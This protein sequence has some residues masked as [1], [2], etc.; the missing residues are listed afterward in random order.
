MVPVKSQKT[1]LAGAGTAVLH[2]SRRGVRP[3]YRDLYG[4]SLFA[5]GTRGKQKAVIRICHVVLAT[6]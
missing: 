3:H 5:R 1:I 6:W 4:G 2:A